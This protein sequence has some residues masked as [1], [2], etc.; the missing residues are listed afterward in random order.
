MKEDNIDKTNM[1][2]E[3]MHILSYRKI[4]IYGTGFVSNRISRIMKDRGLE[5]NIVCYIESEPHDEEFNGKKVIGINKYRWLDETVVI[6][7]HEA[8]LI[9][10][11]HR[12]NEK[13]IREY[14]WIKPYLDRME[15]G[16]TV[17]TRAATA[18][19]MRAHKNDY[20]IAMD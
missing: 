1:Y 18:D 3:I 8:N 4:A 9:S 10:I 14:V 13:G 7:V 11:R 2:D 5:G 6:A 19:V 15:Y 16:D 17:R 20:H 12:L